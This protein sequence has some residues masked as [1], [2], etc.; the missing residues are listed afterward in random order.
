M[1]D[2]GQAIVLGLL[3]VGLIALV[4]S[5]VFGPTHRDRLLAVLSLV[6]SF[7]AVVLIAASD[8]AHEQVVLDRPLDSLNFASQMVV[9]ILLAGLASGLW[10]IGAKAVSKIGSSDS[11]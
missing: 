5:L 6:V 9:V 4:K 3:V 1:L 8:F 11:L 10:Q 2:L 7:V